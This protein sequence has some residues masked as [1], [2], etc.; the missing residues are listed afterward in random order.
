MAP[1]YISREAAC[2]AI[3]SYK[4]DG[5]CGDFDD[6]L[7]LAISVIATMPAAELERVTEY[8]RPVRRVGGF[9]MLLSSTRT[10]APAS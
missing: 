7:D 4:L 6:T 3:R 1:D 5:P 8:V 9:P 2:E 10:D